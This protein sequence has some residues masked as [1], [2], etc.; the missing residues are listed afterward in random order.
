MN[1]HSANLLLDCLHQDVR[2]ADR[3][4]LGAIDTATWEAAHELS[5]VHGVQ[6]L[7]RSRLTERGLDRA[8]PARTL[9]AMRATARQGA[10]RSLERRRDLDRV[11]RALAARGIPV[12]VLKGAY[13]A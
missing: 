3:V 6:E 5:A 12:V 11:C 8:V 1:E 9:A 2:R 13:L 10:I 4:R 7:L